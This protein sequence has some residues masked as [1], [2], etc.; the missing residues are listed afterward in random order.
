MEG[1]PRV[2]VK[3]DCHGNFGPDDFGPG[4]P[5]S[6]ILFGRD[7][8]PPD[9]NHKGILVRL[10]ESAVQPAGTSIPWTEI[11][12]VFLVRSGTPRLCLQ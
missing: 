6:P 4:G 7:F 12:G 10:Q 11:A 1:G 8:G 2:A 9:H 5:K 3:V